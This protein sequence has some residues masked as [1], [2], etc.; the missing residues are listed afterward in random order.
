MQE[1]H[2]LARSP[3]RGWRRAKL[4]AGTVALTMAG[5]GSV[6]VV[7]ALPASAATACGSATGTPGCVTNT[8]TIGSPSGGVN[9]VTVTPT[10]ATTG[11]AQSYTISFVAV[12][13]LATGNTI[14]IG[15][16]LGNA[17]VSSVS[18]QL[19]TVALIS[20]SCLQAGSATNTSASA[21]G[22]VITLQSSSCPSIAAGSTVTVTFNAGTAGPTAEPSGNFNFTVATSTNS[23]AV[24][25][26]TVVVSSAPPTLSASNQSAGQSATYTITGAGASNATGGSWSTLTGTAGVL[27]LNSSASGVVWAPGAASYV[28]TYTPSGGTAATDVVTG[29]TVI[30]G[31]SVAPTSVGLTLTTPIASG[32][33]VNITANVI[34]PP[35]STQGVTITPATGTA[36]PFTP[37]GNTETT[38][39]LSFGTAVKNVTLAISP[40]VAGASATYTIGFTAASG[41]S[42]FDHGV[43]GQHELL[44]RQRRTGH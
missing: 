34:N 31:T 37:V 16:S 33:V 29:V 42:S 28:V 32:G 30:T 26:P 23:T 11:T 2:P 21:S 40:L 12:A 9:N 3:R 22:L 24:N 17:L 4:L 1:E 36:A 6:A 27:V 19:A 13:A 14:T 39:T 10:T 5:F 35:A 38:N 44:G 20:G 18:T 43:R 15:D 25:S 7:S 41:P 8:Y